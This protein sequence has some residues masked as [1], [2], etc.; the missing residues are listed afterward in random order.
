M[1]KIVS[2]SPPATVR[3]T[4]YF[5]PPPGLP[6]D[7]H[8][9]RDGIAPNLA[10]ARAR[11]GYFDDIGTRRTA[12]PV[13]D[14]HAVLHGLARDQIAISKRAHGC[15]VALGTRARGLGDI[16]ENRRLPALEDEVLDR[17][18]PEVFPL[19]DGPAR[20]RVI[21]GIENV[22]DR[23]IVRVDAHIALGIVASEHQAEKGELRPRAGYN[24]ATASSK[25]QNAFS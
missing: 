2:L 21:R 25:A 18:L 13:F 16:S 5:S 24:W 15:E 11:D 3:M 17:F 7:L 20:G 14:H 10:Q 6:H 22:D 12:R 23:R 9:E 19:H 1:V 4:S 8:R